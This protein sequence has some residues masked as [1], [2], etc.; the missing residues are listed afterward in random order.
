MAELELFELLALECRVDLDG[1]LRYYNAQGQIHREYGPAVEGLDGYRAWY[2]NGKRHRADG[3]AVEY[4]DGSREWRQHGRRHRIDGPAVE[5]GDGTYEWW[6][7]GIE[8]T[9]AEW[10]Q[11]VASMGN[12]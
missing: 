8:L 1:T 6:L 7:N 3:P 5:Y 2:Q 10:Q 11:A 12:A 4:N 9:E